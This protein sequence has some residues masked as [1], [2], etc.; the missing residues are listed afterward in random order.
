MTKRLPKEGPNNTLPQPK[1]A[2]APKVRLTATELRRKAHEKEQA[3]QAR[4]NNMV[5]SELLPP[6]LGFYLG[7]VASGD[8][9]KARRLA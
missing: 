3:M 4:I 7:T 5:A 1:E 9:I 8:T 6:D 2:S